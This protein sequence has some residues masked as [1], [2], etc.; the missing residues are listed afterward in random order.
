M[1]K[2]LSVFLIITMLAFIS[3]CT[4]PQTYN[5]NGISFQYPGDWSIDY[6][7]NVQNSFGNSATVMVSLGKENSGVVICKMNVDQ[8]NLNDLT[9]IFKSNMEYSG[10]QLINQ[11]NR[12]VDDNNVTENIFKENSTGIYGSLTF[13]QKNNETYLI[14]VGTPNKDKSDADMILNS[15]KIQ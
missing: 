3:G 6:K 9:Y 11:N 14:I 7:N 15:L 13:L 4:Q 1:R 5:E 2:W 12:K 10:Y 8:I